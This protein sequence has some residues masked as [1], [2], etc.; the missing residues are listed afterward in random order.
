MER[1]ISFLGYLLILGV[2][3]VFCT[4]KK[5]INIRAVGVGLGIQ[6]GLG[7]LILWVPQ[8]AQWFEKI[9]VKVADFL[10]LSSAGSGF[11]FGSLSDIGANGYI[12]AVQVLPTIIFFSAFISILY[13]LGVIQFIITVIAKAMQY[14]MGTS[15]SETLSCSANIF[16]GQTEAPL[17][18]KP[19]ISKMTNSEINAVMIGGFATIAGGVLA[20]YIGMG[21]SATHLIGASLMA[22]PASLAVA[23]LLVPETEVSQTSGDAKMPEIDS[24]DNILDAASRGTT[25]GLKLAL[26]VA[27]MLIAFLSLIAVV[28]WVFGGIDGL[29]DGKLLGGVMGENGEYAGYFP[30][31]MNTLLGTLFRPFVFMLGV[32]WEETK[33]AGSM[34]GIKIVANEFVAF[35]ILSEGIK[36][37]TVSIRT[38]TIMSYALCGFANLSSIGIQ[39]GGIGALAP[40]RRTDLSRLAWRA[41]LGGVLVSCLTACIAG[42]LAPMDGSTNAMGDSSESAI[43]QEVEGELENINSTTG[44]M[45][46]MEETLMET[47][48]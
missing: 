29:I 45:E 24:G 21:I 20:A 15:G 42:M 23:K 10:G 7:M 2:L 35:S 4:N 33:I 32:P 17:L 14:L 31:S 9:T 1:V 19:F 25:D 34:L 38:E 6:F 30:G 40:E 22:A 36:A 41:L 3:F 43:I 5:K 16:V 37:G 39:I 26:N 48:S 18:I 47:G 8:T 11:L 28:D 46:V 12:F 44:P 13:Y 27:A